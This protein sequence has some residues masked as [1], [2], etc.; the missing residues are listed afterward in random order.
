[1]T[2]NLIPS[3]ILTPLRAFLVVGLRCFFCF[4]IV[5]TALFLALGIATLGTI[6]DWTIGE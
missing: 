5:S 3:P 6:V 4:V 1:M 2:F